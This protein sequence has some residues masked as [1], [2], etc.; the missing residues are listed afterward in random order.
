MRYSLR[1]LIVFTT[2]FA[3]SVAT[4]IPGDNVHPDG[5]WK[6][7]RLHE[8]ENDAMWDMADPD[9]G[10]SWGEIGT[11]YIVTIRDGL[12]T[13]TVNLGDSSIVW[14]HQLPAVGGYVRMEKSTT[15]TH[16]TL[17]ITVVEK[18]PRLTLIVGLCLSG[19]LS[20]FGVLCVVIFQ[21]LRR[22]VRNATI[23][24]I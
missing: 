15:D 13:K 8:V 5:V 20:G 10:E 18:L 6:V 2:L 3:I 7:V 4:G 12:T 11:D 23:A 1:H 16:G 19:L 14:D 17:P 21:N 24:P 22:R 9:S